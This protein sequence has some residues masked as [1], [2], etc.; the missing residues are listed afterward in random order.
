MAQIVEHSVNAI[1]HVYAEM[2]IL[3]LLH[4]Y[5]ANA[6][7]II[8]VKKQPQGNLTNVIQHV[9]ACLKIQ[10]TYTCSQDGKCQSVAPDDPMIYLLLQGPSVRQLIHVI[11]ITHMCGWKVQVVGSME[12]LFAIH[13]LSVK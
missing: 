7:A 3:Q 6:S 5:L 2:I 9:Y 1:H 4:V 8:L 11:I 10:K 12:K 13:L